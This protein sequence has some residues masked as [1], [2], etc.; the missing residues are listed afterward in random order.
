[1]VQTDLVK[2][3]LFLVKEFKMLHLLLLHKHSKKFL[4]ILWKKS[5]LL[6]SLLSDIGMEV[7]Q[8][9]RKVPRSKEGTDFP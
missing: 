4:N 9:H 1:M 6:V 2:Q 5:F 3:L 8:S 7:I